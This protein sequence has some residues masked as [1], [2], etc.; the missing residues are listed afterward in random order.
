LAP[1][2]TLGRIRCYRYIPYAAPYSPQAPYEGGSGRFCH[3]G[4][5]RLTIYVAE[6]AEGATCEFYRRRPEFL[7]FQGEIARIR[8]FEMEMLV[9]HV[10]LDVREPAGATQVGIDY[11][12]LRSNDPSETARYAQCRELADQVETANGAGIA[13]PSASWRDLAWNLVLFGNPEPD[14]WRVETCDEIEVPHI[15]PEAVTAIPSGGLGAG[16]P[17][18]P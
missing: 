1:W 12:Q 3:L 13:Y 6:N 18:P 15:D 9:S 5:L 17:T 4:H 10:C 14:W 16:T 8:L 7:P 2:V 11:E